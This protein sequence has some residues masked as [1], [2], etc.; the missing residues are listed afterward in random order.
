[1]N[2]SSKGE[3]EAYRIA[4]K[5]CPT[6]GLQNNNYCLDPF[7]STTNAPTPSGAAP[8]EE[9]RK[10]WL[11]WCR[12]FFIIEVG[13]AGP[14]VPWL[15]EL[16]KAHPENAPGGPYETVADSDGWFVQDRRK[17]GER[18]FSGS[19]LQCNDVRDVLNRLKATPTRRGRDQ[20]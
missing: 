14:H 4:A 16:L 5:M 9:H 11:R 7:H 19:E 6:C 18:R 8:N 17:L 1:M 10:F 2:K 13:I 12:D 3:D 20:R 15:N